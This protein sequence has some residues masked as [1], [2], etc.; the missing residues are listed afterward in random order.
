M[1][2]HILG[3]AGYHPNE[4]RHTACLMIPEL[5]VILDAGTAFFRVRS[6]IQTN[7]LHIFLSH[8]HLDH[9]VGLTFVLDVAF[10]KDLNRICVYGEAEKLQAIRNSLFTEYLFPVLPEFEWVEIQNGTHAL[11]GGGKIK[12]FPLKHPG[13]SLGFRLDVNGS[14]LAYVTDTTAG[15]DSDYIHE[16]EN[17]DLLI[18]ECHFND[19]QEAMAEKTGHSCLTPACQAALDAQVK[20]LVLTHINPL[21]DVAEPLDIDV[22]KRIFPETEFA[23]DQMELDW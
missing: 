17:V 6:L 22:A 13:G 23:Y 8:A 21:D 12:S 20:R 16:I 2:L 9:C 15:R 18:H 10:E 4:N 1:K 7:E 5:G 14:S 3:S 11:P 19:G